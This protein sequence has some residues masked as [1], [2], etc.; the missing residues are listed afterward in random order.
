MAAVQFIAEDDRG[1]GFLHAVDAADLVQQLIQLLRRIGAQPGHVIE[2]AA[3]GAELLDL[4]H[5]AEPAQHVLARA[6]LHGDADISLQTA[7][8]DPLAKAHAV[9]G[10]HLG[11]FQ[12]RQARRHRGARDT[13]L[14]GKHGDAF[15]SVDLQ[16]GDQLAIDFI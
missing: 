14:P 5:G 4:S 1:G 10:N 8:H 6:C 16:S 2:L 11:F 12:A 13:Q 9:T 7:I 15:A 3:H